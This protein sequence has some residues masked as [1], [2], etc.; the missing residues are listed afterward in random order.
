[1]SSKTASVPALAS[2][3]S[4]GST[5]RG[6]GVAVGDTTTVSSVTHVDGVAVDATVLP[7]SHP[8]IAGLLKYLDAREVPSF[9]G[10]LDFDTF[11]DMVALD[12]EKA[13]SVSLDAKRSFEGPLKAPRE[14]F[15]SCASL[16]DALVE[17]VEERN[18]VKTLI[19][20]KVPGYKEM[21]DERVEADHAFYL[22]CLD[23]ID[24]STLM[25]CGVKKRKRQT[26]SDLK[27]FKKHVFG[28]VNSWD[29]AKNAFE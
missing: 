7:T 21:R 16:P 19:D 29:V 2:A 22:K 14:A 28:L 11:P 5:V 3:S 24:E 1:M 13:K 15:H 8:A 4:G 27:K 17:K 18:L 6:G 26:R 12:E 25:A 10:T 23:D 20:A 9:I